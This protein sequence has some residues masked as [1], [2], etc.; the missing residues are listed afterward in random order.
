[1]TA[2]DKTSSDFCSFIE[3]KETIKKRNKV[4][5]FFSLYVNDNDEHLS[6][7]IKLIRI[8]LSFVVIRF[9]IIYLYGCIHGN[10]P[11][12][13]PTLSKFDEIFRVCR[14]FFADHF[15]KKNF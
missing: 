13:T 11:V 10:S 8:F 4:S 14:A 9:S 6:T 1:M 15:S 3:V 2:R 12:N 7:V 5:Y